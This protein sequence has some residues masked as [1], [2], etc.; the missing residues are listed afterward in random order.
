MA[1]INQTKIL[2]AESESRILGEARLLVKKGEPV[3]V[4]PIDYVLTANVPDDP[5]LAAFVASAKPVIAEAQNRLALASTPAAPPPAPAPSPYLTATA[6][7]NCHL[8][9]FSIWAASRHAQAMETL[10]R[11]KKE[12]DTSCVPCHS[13][14]AGKPGGFA[15]LYKTPLLANVQCEACHGGGSKHVQ[16]PA[17]NLL[18]TSGK[19]GCLVCHTKSNSPEFNFE[20]YW[21]K[22]SHMNSI[23]SSSQKQP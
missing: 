19:A 9:A 13:T 7:R 20:T 4:I 3:Q 22:I 23:K 12:F 2:Y 1:Q 5:E 6:C 11:A 18:K 21:K 17:A 8:K 14:A 15:D 16:N 10:K